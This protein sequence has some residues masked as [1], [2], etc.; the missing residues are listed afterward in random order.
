MAPHSR[1]PAA[2]SWA[3]KA[4]PAGGRPNDARSGPKGEAMT[5]ILSASLV[6]L[7]PRPE[8][9]GA[10]KLSTLMLQRSARMGS[11]F[12]SAVVFPGGA[13]D[14]ADEAA[15]D[16]PSSISDRDEV[17]DQRYLRALRLCALR[18]TFEET[19]LL[20]L[21][22]ER[23]KAGR[24]TY[25]RAIGA[26]EAG[27]TAKEWAQHRDAVHDDASL[28]PAFL[29]GIARRAGIQGDGLP[30]A[31]LAYHSHWITPKS[32]VRP[33]KRFSAH[34]FVTILEG[35]DE[36]TSPAGTTSKS[37]P[38]DLPALA[39]SADGTETLSL[40]VAP[41][42]EFIDAT[43]R[44]QIVLYPPQFYILSDLS[45]MTKRARTMQDQATL[46]APLDFGLSN[47]TNGATV[48]PVEE[49]ARNI[50][51]RNY[52][53]D[54]SSQQPTGWVASQ[55][56]EEATKPVTRVEPRALPRHGGAVALDFSKSDATAAGSERA[57]ATE[58]A[59]EEA[60]SGEA[61]PFVFPLV[62]P[63]DWQASRVQRSAAGG[64]PSS[65]DWAS[66]PEG[67]R[68]LNRVYV[69]PRQKQDGGGLIPRGAVR[70][71]IVGLPDWRIG[72]SLPEGT[73]A[74]EELEDEDEDDR[75]AGAAPTKSR[76]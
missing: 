22:S 56:G 20:L 49:E 14:L 44:D 29:A 40:K 37:S 13:L 18:E 6:V 31:S 30:I 67:E 72:V 74:D 46:L 39:L 45:Q 34:F 10:D 11:S 24:V 52:A 17:K 51:S 75:R 25:S 70:R 73:G 68:P 12:R 58:K 19:G 57:D 15:V 5:P 4:L 54:R 55:S 66:K 63:G 32:V 28:F 3:G 42:D 64:G 53:W 26:K 76:L 59:T 38:A 43:L 21:P 16:C 7:V 61:E 65:S 60:E 36:L 1:K 9:S 23:R 47:N 62:L 27:L 50:G 41:V 35:A 48:T 8:A 33:G 71:G 2:G 69:S